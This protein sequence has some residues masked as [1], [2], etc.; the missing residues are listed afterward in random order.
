M[1]NFILIGESDFITPTTITASSEASGFPGSNLLDVHKPGAEWRSTATTEQNIVFDTG[2]VGCVVTA[3]FLGDVNFTSVTIQGNAT[4]SWGSPSFSQAFTVSKDNV[5][6]RYKAFAALT[7]FAYR[8]LRLL[9]P[10]Q[11]PTDSEAFFRIGTAI[12]ASWAGEMEINP[13]YGGYAYSGQKLSKTEEIAGSVKTR[14]M[15]LKKQFGCE[16]SIVGN[17]EHVSNFWSKYNA[18][19]PGAAF[20]LYE[21]GLYGGGTEKAYLL[22]MEDYAE[23]SWGDYRQYQ[24]RMRFME[25]L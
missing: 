24:G 7:G 17:L 1:P 4:D 6:Q 5:V 13:E 9:V 14:V 8:Y 18:E 20:I 2:T 22:E 19:D 23:L 25:K 21:N 15:S 3:V 10:A 12:P 11:S 16:M